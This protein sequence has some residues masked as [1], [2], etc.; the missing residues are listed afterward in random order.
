MWEMREYLR[1]KSCPTNFPVET[2]VVTVTPTIPRSLLGEHSTRYIVWDVRLMPAENTPTCQR[3]KVTLIN[4]QRILTNPLDIRE[5]NLIPCIHV[6]KGY[7]S[8]T[9]THRAP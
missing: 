4:H 5:L 2:N 1:P 8:I 7:F 3:L 6:E 9:I